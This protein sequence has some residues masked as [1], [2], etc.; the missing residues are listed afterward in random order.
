MNSGTQFISLSISYAILKVIFGVAHEVSKEGVGPPQA[1]RHSHELYWRFFLIW[2]FDDVGGGC[3]PTCCSK[4]S[5]R[6]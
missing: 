6:A 2:C 5:H 3:C 1:L 4:I